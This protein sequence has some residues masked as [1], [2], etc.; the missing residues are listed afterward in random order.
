MSNTP[1]DHTLPTELEAFAKSIPMTEPTK[2]TKPKQT[3]R[4]RP[5]YGCKKWYFELLHWKE[6]AELRGKAVAQLEY[7]NNCLKADKDDVTDENI[8]LKIDLERAQKNIEDVKDDCDYYKYKYFDATDENKE[9]RDEIKEVK[10]KSRRLKDQLIH[11]EGF[12]R[13]FVEG[14]SI[15]KRR[16]YSS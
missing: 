9:L 11:A 8:K 10:G 4:K 5:R 6:K 2:H 15:A 14:L 1:A 12:N 16:R 13:G 7:E 3:K